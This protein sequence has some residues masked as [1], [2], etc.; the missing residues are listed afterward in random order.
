MPNYRL[1]MPPEP[2]IEDLV[3]LSE[4]WERS[5]TIREKLRDVAEIVS[6]MTIA[7]ASVGR[8][9]A[10]RLSMRES[11]DQY[12]PE[13]GIAAVTDKSIEIL[14]EY[15]FI[16]AMAS[17]AESNEVLAPLAVYATSFAAGFGA[18]LIEVHESSRLQ[19]T[20]ETVLGNPGI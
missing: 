6:W 7:P 20:T 2:P 9:M 12:D 15:T 11:S 1:E 16:S 17:F 8:Y 4:G 14:D 3:D 13:E 19:D 5:P 10:Y 18:G